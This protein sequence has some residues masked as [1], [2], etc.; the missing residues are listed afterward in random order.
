MCEISLGHGTESEKMADVDLKRV[1]DDAIADLGE[2]HHATVSELE[3]AN[4]AEA[5]EYVRFLE[6]QVESIAKVSK[7]IETAMKGKSLPFV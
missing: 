4:E 5:E 6:S 2:M 1:L 7:C 3:K